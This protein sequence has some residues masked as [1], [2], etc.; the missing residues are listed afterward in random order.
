MKAHY[1]Y[2]YPVE[3]YHAYCQGLNE[4]ITHYKHQQLKNLIDSQRIIHQY[5]Y[6]RL[7]DDMERVYAKLP[8]TTRV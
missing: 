8:L 4:L 3:D 6:Q 1:P 5:S 7:I 2:T